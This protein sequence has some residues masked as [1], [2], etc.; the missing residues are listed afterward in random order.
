[1]KAIFQYRTRWAT[2]A[3]LAPVRAEPRTSQAG[4]H[5]CRNH[6]QDRG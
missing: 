5:R 1:L 6:R 3:F 2:G 4:Q